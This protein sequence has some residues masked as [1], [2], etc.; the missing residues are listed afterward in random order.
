MSNENI[1]RKILK[2]AELIYLRMHVC[3]CVCVWTYVRCVGVCVRVCLC[4][5]GYVR[6]E[7]V[8]V[9]ELKND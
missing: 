1:Y 5:W 2:V 4:V 8:H 7:G 6:C 9:R 3:V